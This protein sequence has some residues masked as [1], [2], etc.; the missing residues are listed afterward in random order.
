MLESRTP[1][2][3]PCRVAGLPADERPST[4]LRFP[5]MTVS[6]RDVLAWYGRLPPAAAPPDPTGVTLMAALALG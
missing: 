5:T 3:G 6:V 2:Y 1:V 4:P